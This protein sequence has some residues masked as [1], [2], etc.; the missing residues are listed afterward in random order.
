VAKLT[1]DDLKPDVFKLARL[2]PI[3]FNVI[4]EAFNPDIPEY[5]DDEPIVH[6]FLEKCLKINCLKYSG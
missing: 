3:T 1:R 4:C 5:N 2:S 6:P